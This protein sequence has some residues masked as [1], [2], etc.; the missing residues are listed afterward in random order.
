MAAKSEKTEA[1]DILLYPHLAEKSM[2][3]VD[4]ENKIVFVVRQ[5]ANKTQI[6]VA[7]E[8]GFGVKVSAVKTEVTPRGQKKAYVKLHPDHSAAD[9]ASRL[10]IL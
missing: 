5:D 4:L 3:M 9:L 7:I 10:G 8:E 2:N 6:K 1:W